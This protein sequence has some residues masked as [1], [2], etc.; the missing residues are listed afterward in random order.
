MWRHKGSSKCLDLDPHQS[1]VRWLEF[2]TL[3]T[4]MEFLHYQEGGTKPETA[5]SKVGGWRS[6]SEPKLNSEVT[7]TQGYL[8]CSLVWS[9]II[10]L[11]PDSAFCWPPRSS[12]WSLW[13]M[14]WAPGLHVLFRWFLPLTLSLQWNFPMSLE[15]HSQTRE[16]VL[17]ES[18]FMY[19][20]TFKD[21][22]R[23]FPKCSAKMRCLKKTISESS[24]KDK[25]VKITP[26]FPKNVGG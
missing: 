4:W 11:P 3:M 22:K 10:F 21:L 12:I 2:L 13:A 1:R 7:E 6:A 16:R 8:F 19:F 24:I 17:K 25:Q 5:K 26:I 23:Y 15:I 14:T 20:Y 18:F 9:I